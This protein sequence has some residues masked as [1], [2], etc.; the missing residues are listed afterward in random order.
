[1]E[2]D[3]PGKEIDKDYR[4]VV[5]YLIDNEGW[6]YKLP[7]GGGYPRLLPADRSK[8]AIKVPKSGHTRGRRFGNW[9]GEVRR[10]GGHWPPGRE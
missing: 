2:T 5:S 8:P 7:P 3:R 6:L 9:I 1:M 4:E 10:A